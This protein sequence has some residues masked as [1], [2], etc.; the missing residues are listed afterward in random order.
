MILYR[1]WATIASCWSYLRSE[2]PRQPGYATGAGARERHSLCN[3]S[4]S[5]AGNWRAIEQR[6]QE[7][8]LLVYAA[9]IGEFHPLKPVIDAY[10][11]RYPDTQLV[12]LS[13][14][15]QYCEAILGTYPQAAVGVPPPGAPW[16]YDRLF[17]LANPR[18]VAIGEGPCLHLH[19]PIPLE[20]ALP[21]ACKRHGVPLVV[22]NSTM[23]PYQPASRLERLEGRLFGSLYRDAIGCWFTQNETFRSWLVDAGVPEE[24]IVVTGDLRFDAQRP[25]GERS[26]EFG[27][28]LDELAGRSGPIIVAGSVNAIDEQAPVIDG[29]LEV[30]KRYPDATLV[31]APRHIN[32]PENMGRLY[33]FLRETNVRF[34]RRSEGIEAALAAEA[35]VVDVFGELPHYYSVAAVAYI[36]RNHT[37]LEPLRFEVPTVVAPRSDWATGYVTFPAYIQLVDE[38]GVIEAED[39]SDLGR[40][41][42]DIIEDPAHGRSFVSRALALA[43]RQK[44][45]STRI[46]E[47]VASLI[48]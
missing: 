2:R 40:I 22:V 31:I 19:F 38:K 9:T 16:L 17:R 10:L 34:A 14:Q 37:L 43:D 25:L 44:G 33:E 13:G 8:S 30:R 32:N 6:Q 47:H 15:W 28:L 11:D 12:I 3:L 23:F 35:I 46:V 42:L 7:H 20:L 45:A 26:A 4:E 1:L 24:R 36:G 29:W 39:K 27:A 48:R 18:L 41:F 21:A 5:F